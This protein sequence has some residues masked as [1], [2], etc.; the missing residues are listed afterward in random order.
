MVNKRPPKERLEKLVAQG[1][2]AR[3]I[4]EACGVYKT[5][6]SGWLKTYGL[7]TLRGQRIKAM[8]DPPRRAVHEII[9]KPFYTTQEGQVLYKH[10]AVLECGH[11]KV[12]HHSKFEETH[13]WCRKCPAIKESE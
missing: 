9:H 12:I 13:F 2:T 3:E 6:A 11:Q 4:A 8:G 5:V 7:S 1:H 10:F